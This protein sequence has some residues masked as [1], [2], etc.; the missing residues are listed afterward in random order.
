MSVSAAL[1]LDISDLS[2][3]INC[4]NMPGLISSR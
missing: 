3:E 1:A 4:E 2:E